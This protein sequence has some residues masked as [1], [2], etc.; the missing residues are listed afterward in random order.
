MR[1]H[2]YANDQEIACKAVGG[3]GASN[4]AFPD[5]CWSPPP[6]SAGPVVISY[7]NSCEAT[8]LT[9]GTAT[10]F[11]CGK[12]VARADQSYFST[13]TGNEGATQAFAKG[14]ATG[15]IV[16]KA[17]FTQWSSDV[18]FEGYGVPRHED[19]VSHNHGSMPSNTP[20][21]PYIS[22]GWFSHDCSAEEKRIER[23][24]KPESEQSDSKKEIKKHSKL[25]SLLNK[26]K[27]KN[28]VGRRGKDG[29][30]WTDD[31]CGGLHFSLDSASAAQEYAKDMQDIFNKI[32][33]EKE[34]LGALE[35]ELKDMAFRAGAKAAAKWTAKAGLKQLGGSTIPLAGN[36]AMGLWSAYDA[37]VAIGDVSEIKAVAEETLEELATLKN[38]FA[39]IENLGKEFK[40]FDKLSLGEQA[41]KAQALGA[42]GQD[43]L[44]T[45]N[46]CTRARKCNLVPYGKDGAGNLLGQRGKSNVESA[47]GGGCCPGQTGHHLIPGGSIKESCPNYDHGTAPTVCVEGTSQNHGSHKRVHVALAKEHRALAKGGKIA[48]DNTMSMDDAIDAAAKSHADAFPLSRCSKKCIRAQLA[49]YYAICRNARAKMVNEQSKPEKP[50]TG[51][52]D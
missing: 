18:V 28:K 36:I 10:V 32:P 23:A 30:H 21:F 43:L 8:H 5:P 44:A 38:K 52:T 49:S 22:R 34:I 46:S 24:C 7:P 47:S 25:T 33:G 39:D 13:S 14:F 17:Y 42:E 40:N 20:V 37:A 4:A 2:V 27:A 3:D 50:G 41:E 16:G 35:G 29:K 12:E 45:L 6:P 48:A 31:H 11:I 9:N 1:T 51:D 26:L 15:V 19:L